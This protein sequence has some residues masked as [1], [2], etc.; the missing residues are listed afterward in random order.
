M[1]LQLVV[2]IEQGE[3]QLLLS[4]SIVGKDILQLVLQQ[5]VLREQCVRQ[6]RSFRI[7]RLAFEAVYLLRLQRGI[8]HLESIESLHELRRDML[9]VGIEQDAAPVL[10][11]ESSDMLCDVR[12]PT[13]PKVCVETGGVRVYTRLKECAEELLCLSMET[14]LR[15]GVDDLTVERHELSSS[16][17]EGDLTCEHGVLHHRHALVPSEGG[18]GLMLELATDMHHG[19]MLHEMT[20]AL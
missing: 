4:L 10:S 6:Q 20:L 12:C 9:L 3:T 16:R 1:A 2:E 8:R 11:L 17:G 18:K 19:S 7:L 15:V 5:Q 13:L 14:E